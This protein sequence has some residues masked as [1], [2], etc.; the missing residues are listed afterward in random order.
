M[1]NMDECRWK[2]LAGQNDNELKFYPCD[3]FDGTLNVGFK[4]G[5]SAS[6]S[7]YCSHCHTNIRKPEELK[8]PT[9]PEIMTKYWKD[10]GLWRSVSG[11]NPRDKSYTMDNGF[12]LKSWFIDKESADIPPE[13]S[14][15]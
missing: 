14:I 4:K 2:R 9:H 8:Q 6:S 15:D 7:F 10:K 12:F 3:D 5:E 13:E 1:N 11:Y